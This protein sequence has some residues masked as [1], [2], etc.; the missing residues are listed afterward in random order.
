MGQYPS[1]LSENQHRLPA[2]GLGFHLLC[3]GASAGALLWSLSARAQPFGDGPDAGVGNDVVSAPAPTFVAAP[4][5]PPP[6][7][8]V[9]SAQVGVRSLVV[10]QATNAPN[11]LNDVGA[12]GEADVVLSGQV[13]RFLRWQAGF[14]GVIGDTQQTSA[15]LLDLV[16]KLEFADFFNLWLGRMPIPSDRT[17]LSTVWAIAPATLPGHYQSFSAI[18]PPGARPA[19]G[20]RQGDLDR[21]DGA[22]L[23]GQIRGGR[24]KYY[25][26]AFGLDQVENQPLYSARLALSLL[27][28][29][30]GFR[31]S[32][33]YYG[34][35]DVLTVGVG[36]QHQSNGSLPPIGMP[37]PPPAAA[38]NEVNVD[39]LFE[40]GGETAGVLDLEGAFARMWGANEDAKY[41]CFGLAS[42]LVPLEVGFGRF[43]PLM[44]VQR[45]TPGAGEISADFTS[46]DTQLGYVVDGHHARLSAGWQYTRSH[47]QPANAVLLGIQLLSRTK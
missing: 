31:N 46:L 42:Y 41:Q 8:D 25:L 44:R 28:P 9:I 1:V 43:Q 47:G 36:A 20:P 26:G 14:A 24:L 21:G 16:A 17:S 40:V 13:H 29:E 15:T 27:S 7:V 32:S 5:S 6:T 30:P 3:V 4:V 23:W 10:V 34:G 38:F 11:K 39:V 12:V 19:A 33:S 2:V 45:A 37:T 35:K 18:A 22:L